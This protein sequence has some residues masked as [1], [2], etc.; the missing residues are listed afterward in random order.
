MLIGTTPTD[1]TLPKYNG[2][3]FKLSDST[4]KTILLSFFDIIQQWNWISKLIE[5][6]N[7][8][9]ILG[10]STEI[11]II[12]VIYN[13]LDA[14]TETVNGVNYSGSVDNFWIMDKISATGITGFNFPILVN[15]GWASSFALNYRADI[16]TDP[17]FSGITNNYLINYLISKDFKVTDKW[18]LDTTINANPIS[19]NHIEIASTPAFDSA[20]LSLNATYSIQRI[21]NLNADPKIMYT[22]PLET[23]PLNTISI[24]KMY[25]SKLVVDAAGDST[26][27]SLSG[28]G[29]TSLSVSNADFSGR[30]QVE[31]VVELTIAGTLQDGSLNITLSLA[32]TD[33]SGTPIDTSEN[34]IHYTIDL[35]PRI[36]GLKINPR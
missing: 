7:N 34:T 19:F 28:S 10:I 2:G 20:D 24:I 36:T 31:N 18:H 21:I 1:F 30:N 14:G 27:Y 35:P 17:A 5:I 32:I 16:Q 9:S 6:Q 25:Y 33:T 29:S 13:Y 23:N 3:N 4:G 22:Q 12:A 11:Q 26:K 15:G 8:P